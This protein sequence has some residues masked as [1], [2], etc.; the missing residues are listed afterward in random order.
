MNTYRI[1]IQFSSRPYKGRFKREIRCI[2]VEARS[3][4]SAAQVARD[5]AANRIGTRI[6]NCMCQVFTVHSV[7]V[8][9][10]LF[11]D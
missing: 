9:M 8:R 10:D 7:E 5:L 3:P 2:D 1:P 11:K 4:L 6:A